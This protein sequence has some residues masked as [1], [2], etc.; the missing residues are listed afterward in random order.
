MA[1]IKCEKCGKEI[2][3]TMNKC[4]HCGYERK[5]TTVKSRP[6]YNGNLIYEVGNCETR[7]ARS[8]T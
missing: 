3:S 1:L 7:D 8:Q 5:E 4:P 2:S 6:I